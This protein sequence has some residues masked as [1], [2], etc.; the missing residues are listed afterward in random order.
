MLGGWASRREKQGSTHKSQVLDRRRQLKS[1][2]CLNGF[3]DCCNSRF[4][5]YSRFWGSSWALTAPRI[6]FSLLFLPGNVTMKVSVIWR[7]NLGK[8][9]RVESKSSAHSTAL[10]S[11]G[12]MSRS[13]NWTR[14]WTTECG[15]KLA[16]LNSTSKNIRGNRKF[17]NRNG[18]MNISIVIVFF[19]RLS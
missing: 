6:V 8:D 11:D 14:S 5:T 2:K 10:C 19:R 12:P 17:W 18:D 3:W 16:R 13:N 9:Q 15:T 7:V 1:L 4:W